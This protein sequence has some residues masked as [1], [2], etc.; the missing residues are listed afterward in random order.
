M[1]LWTKGTLITSQKSKFLGLITTVKSSADARELIAGLKH[2]KSLKTASHYIS[3]LRIRIG[4]SSYLEEAQ[5][6]GEPP[7]AS[8]LMNILKQANL[9]DTLLVVL[10][11]YGGK[12]LGPSRF[13]V[14][15]EAGKSAVDE[16]QG[17]KQ[18]NMKLLNE[19]K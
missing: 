16:F 14:I 12:H 7:A 19:N 13:R 6:N 17:L 15:D 2:D 10:R 1:N 18:T 3:A 11:W 8:R 4:D 5:N 9:Y